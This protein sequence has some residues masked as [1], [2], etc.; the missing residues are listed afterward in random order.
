MVLDL[1][2]VIR[3]TDTQVS[4]P[5]MDEVVLMNTETGCYYSSEGTG[6]HIWDLLDQPQSLDSLAQRLSEVYDVSPER[7]C[8][9]LI[10]YIEALQK[11]GLV[12]IQT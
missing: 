8:K 11:R 10:P 3:K 5:L 7:C 6:K 12:R 9:G 2:A 4:C 1:H